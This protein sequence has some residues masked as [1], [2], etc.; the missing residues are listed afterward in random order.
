MIVA[1]GQRRSAARKFVPPKLMLTSMM[2]MFTIILIF[3]LF[4]FSE[5]PEKIKLGED[6]Q[7]PRSTAEAK[8]QQAVK[9]I[10]TKTELRVDDEV[11][12]KVQ[13]QKIKGLSSTDAQSSK[14]YQRLKQFRSD[15]AVDAQNEEK[16]PPHILFLCDKSHAFETINSVI[17]ASGLAGYPN[18]QF[19]VLEEKHK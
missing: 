11:V 6:L 12:A 17:K 14:F 16:D 3:L 10:L 1:L 7:L 5:A 19:G 15:V 9:I 13:G 4:S 18:F 2:D 8:Y